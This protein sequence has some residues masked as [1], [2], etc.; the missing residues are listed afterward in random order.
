MGKLSDYQRIEHILGYCERIESSLARHHSDYSEFLS[1]DE[2]RDSIAMKVLQIG[3]LAN[4]LSDELKLKTYQLC[5]WDRLTQQR[6]KYA[7]HYEGVN[8]KGI[9]NIAV[10][11]VPHL[12]V[13]CQQILNTMQTE[14]DEPNPQK[15]GV[16]L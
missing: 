13:Q 14:Q 12:K 7:H 2:F 11:Y 16:S 8:V 9:W 4:D 6:N 5:Q 10:S 3:E 15:H 1:N